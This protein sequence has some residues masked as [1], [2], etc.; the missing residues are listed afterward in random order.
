MTDD[1]EFESR[2][3]GWSDAEQFIAREVRDM[4]K[5]CIPCRVQ[6]AKHETALTGIGGAVAVL[7]ILFIA[8]VGA[9]FKKLFD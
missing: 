3:A 9:A 2:I 8:A 1:M 4:K 6:V 7:T 5:I